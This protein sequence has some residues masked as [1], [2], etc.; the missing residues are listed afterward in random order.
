MRSCD[1]PDDSLLVSE[2]LDSVC[3]RENDE[4]NQESD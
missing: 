3:E 4:E 1:R 2:A